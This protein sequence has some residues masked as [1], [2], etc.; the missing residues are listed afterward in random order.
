[1]VEFQKNRNVLLFYPKEYEIN[2]IFFYEKYK[3]EKKFY[4]K[5]KNNKNEKEKQIMLS[6]DFKI[7][8]NNETISDISNENN[9]NGINNILSKKSFT[10]LE[11]KQK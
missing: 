3:K 11:K 9:I 2:L 8:K 1:M 6:T 4:L 10:K 7:L 5:V